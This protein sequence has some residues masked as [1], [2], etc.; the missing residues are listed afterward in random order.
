MPGI[1]GASAQEGAGI[2]E[3]QVSSHRETGA[4]EGSLSNDAGAG[5]YSPWQLE[6]MRP[7]LL[8]PSTSSHLA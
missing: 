6:Q 1:C 5:S 7:S 3:K 4:R 2:E 8:A